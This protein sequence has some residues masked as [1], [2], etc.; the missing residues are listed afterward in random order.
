M[1]LLNNSLF[2]MFVVALVFIFI[3]VGAT[4]FIQRRKAQPTEEISA[5]LLALLVEMR[6]RLVELAQTVLAAYNKASDGYDAFEEYIIDLIYDTVQEADV[7]TDAEKGLVTKDLLIALLR[8][9]MEEL[10]KKKLI[11]TK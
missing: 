8:P 10:Y 3:G 2:M 6:P 5:S 7:L 9:E 4:L 1:E 11:E